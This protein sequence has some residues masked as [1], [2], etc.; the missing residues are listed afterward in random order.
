[1]LNWKMGLNVSVYQLTLMVHFD[2]DTDDCNH[3]DFQMRYLYSK[4][5]TCISPPGA[6]Y[7]N[8]I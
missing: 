2:L 4:N 1:M 5:K 6:P 7:A 3:A 8:M